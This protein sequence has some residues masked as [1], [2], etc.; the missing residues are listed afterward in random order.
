MSDKKKEL[1]DLKKLS[2]LLDPVRKILQSDELE[3]AIYLLEKFDNLCIEVEDDLKYL[4]EA[5]EYEMPSM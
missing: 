4:E 2:E 3:I 1:D 5:L